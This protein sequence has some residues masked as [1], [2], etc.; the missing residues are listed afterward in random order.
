MTRTCLC[1][2]MMASMIFMLVHGVF[3]FS[4]T[5]VVLRGSGAEFL[6]VGFFFVFCFIYWMSGVLLNKLTG[7]TIFFP[8]CAGV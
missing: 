3:L 6:V 1:D 4:W 2:I 8:A 7:V 5:G